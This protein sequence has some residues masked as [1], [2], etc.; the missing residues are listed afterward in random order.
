MYC[1]I[2]QFPALPFCGP[3]PKPRE[4]RGLIKHD[5]LR[6]YPKLDRGICVIRRIPFACV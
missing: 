6:F 3:H 1:D 2:N 4:A 5:H